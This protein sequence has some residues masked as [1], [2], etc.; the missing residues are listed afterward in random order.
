LPAGEHNSSATYEARYL[1]LAEL[2]RV[3]LWTG[4]RR[5]AKKANA[6]APLMHLVP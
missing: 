5:L 2:L 6:E 3:P 1:A 4:D